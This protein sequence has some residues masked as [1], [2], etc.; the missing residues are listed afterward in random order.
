MIGLKLDDHRAMWFGGASIV[1]TPADSRRVFIYDTRNRR[2]HEVASLPAA[3]NLTDQPDNPD[4]ATNTLVAGVLAD[5]SVVITGGQV[6][7]TDP[8]VN[9][10]NVL[11]YRYFPNQ[12]RWMRTG[13]FPEPQTMSYMPSDLLRDGRLFVIGGGTPESQ[14]PAG[15]KSRAAFVY[16]PRAR[17]VVDGVNPVTGRPTGHQH[18]VR[19]AWDYTRTAR[20]STVAHERT[21][22]LRQL[23]R[24]ERRTS[25]RDRRTHPMGRYLGHVHAH[26]FL[27]PAHRRVVTRPRAASDRGRGRPHPGVTR[28]PRQRSVHDDAARRQGRGRGWGKR[29][30]RS[31][32]LQHHDLAAEHPDPHARDTSDGQ[33]LPAFS[34]RASVP[35]RQRAPVR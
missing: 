19:G 10:E 18:E 22:R 5:G 35:R 4:S 27:R 1:S 15:Q 17:T 14:K 29:H 2:F 13:D 12:D 33:H 11:S 25:A 30:G 34:G 9:A 28:R 21:A 20:R 26:R 31:R 24:V 3:K 16:D 8:A 7:L 32:I 6:S 23:R